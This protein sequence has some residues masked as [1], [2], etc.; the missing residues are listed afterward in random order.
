MH[1]IGTLNSDCMNYFIYQNDQI[2]GP[3]TIGSLI[4]AVKKG[5][6]EPS[7]L[8]SEGEADEWVAVS[9]VIDQKKEQYAKELEQEREKA[10]AEAELQA[11][12][13]RLKE[14]EQGRRAQRFFA[15]I[16][17]WLVRDEAIA[18]ACKN[19][20]IPI[21]ELPQGQTQA[22]FQER[23]RAWERPRQEQQGQTQAEFQERARGQEQ[24]GIP[25]TL[26]DVSQWMSRNQGTVIIVML[27]IVIGAQFFSQVKP[28]VR[29]E[30][31]LES[32]SDYSFTKTMNNYGEQGW[33]LVSA[34]RASDSSSS[35]SYECIFKRP[36]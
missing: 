33:E 31:M 18:F 28:T 35:M 16:W 8:A 7:T 24:Q 22:E 1:I 3:Y 34:R 26:S 29:W 6:I 32:P 15:A 17:N 14:R 23:A 21:Q 2:N 27:L 13:A 12:E 10:L 19:L 4:D 36:K 25:Q 5:N 9:V 30:Y 11:S 20:Y